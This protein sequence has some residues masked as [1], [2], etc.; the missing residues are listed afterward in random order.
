MVRRPDLI[1]R[2]QEA[3]LTYLTI[4]VE[5]FREQE[6][7]ELNTRTSAETNNEA[8]CILKRLKVCNSAHFIVHPD[9]LKEDFEDLFCYVCRSELFPLVFMVLT[10]L[11]GT[12]LY[13]NTRDRLV[14]RDYSYFDFIHSVLPTR[15]PRKEFYAQIVRLYMR[16]YSLLPLFPFPVRRG[17]GP[18]GGSAALC[19]PEG[20]S[21]LPSEA[22]RRAHCRVSACC[23][24]EADAQAGAAD[25]RKDRPGHR[26]LPC[27]LTAAFP[28]SRRT[29]LRVIWRGW[30]CAPCAPDF[31]RDL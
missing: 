27:G 26:C 31:R 24:D 23:P 1:E 14:I 22:L 9:Y 29:R 6:L 5:S 3:G 30:P 8:I 7:K 15:L 11:P 12:E 21:P 19:P 25:K 20:G 17:G 28:S 13:A 18:V 16:T 10:P 2:L 4:G